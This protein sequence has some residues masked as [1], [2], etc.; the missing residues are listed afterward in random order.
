MAALTLSIQSVLCIYNAALLLSQEPCGKNSPCV[1]LGALSEHT[2]RCC[3]VHTRPY[4]RSSVPTRA[5]V[6]RLAAAQCV[7]LA[8]KLMLGSC[9]GTSGVAAAA[10]S[11]AQQCV[12]TDALQFVA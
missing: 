6:V 4:T 5:I 11:S 1:R 2:S 3:A 12:H 7:A 8:H 9:I 10:A